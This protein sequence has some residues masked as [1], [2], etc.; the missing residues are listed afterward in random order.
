MNSFS[1]QLPQ[2]AKAL[3]AKAHLERRLGRALLQFQGVEHAKSSILSESGVASR[4]AA[5]GAANEL[6]SIDAVHG[7]GPAY[8]LQSTKRARQF[9]NVTGVT[10]VR[11]KIWR[12]QNNRQT[13]RFVPHLRPVRRFC[14]LS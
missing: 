6:R 3:P 2:D 10:M 7:E 8:I 5:A 12:I 11:T 13:I 1:R 14:R 9:T 4:A